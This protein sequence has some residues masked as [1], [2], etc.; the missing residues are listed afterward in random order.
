MSTLTT[1]S[2]IAIRW[3]SNPADMGYVGNPSNWMSSEPEMRSPRTALDFASD[4]SQRIGQGTYRRISYQHAG[5]EVTIA[6]M[7]DLV[8]GAD[9]DRMAA[10]G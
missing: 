9:Y 6:E 7:Q 5:R 2:K 10:R 8:F 4:L 3:T 1:R